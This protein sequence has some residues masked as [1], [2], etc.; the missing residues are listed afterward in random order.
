MVKINKEDYEKMMR[1]M[2]TKNLSDLTNLNLEL[3]IVEETFL[4]ALKENAHIDMTL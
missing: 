3:D 2:D 4:D 1:A